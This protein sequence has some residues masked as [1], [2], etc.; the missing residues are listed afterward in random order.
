M[1]F[2]TEVSRI[3]SGLKSGKYR[4]KPNLAKAFM[5]PF[6]KGIERQELERI[7]K[8]KEDRARAAAAAKAA[9]AEQRAKEKA[10]A[11]AQDMVNFIIMTNP[12]IEAT[13]AINKQL[14]T[15]AKTGDFKDAGAFQTFIDDNV[16]Y[17]AGRTEFEPLNKVVGSLPPEMQLR[18]DQVA[19]ENAALNTGALKVGYDAREALEIADFGSTKIPQPDP[20]AV[21]TNA[22]LGMDPV[23]EKTVEPTLTFGKK[24]EDISEFFSGI[25]DIDDWNSKGSEI[26][27]MP[28]GP[29][30][31]RYITAWKTIGEEKRFEAKDDV[32]SMPLDQ[33]R[34][35]LSDTSISTERRELLE[36]RLKSL[37]DPATYEPT[38]LYHSNGS[39]VTARTADEEAAYLSQGFSLVEGPE[40]TDYEA[41]VL[42]KDGGEVKVFS[43][44]QQSEY[45]A[46]GYSVE[47]PAAATP[48]QKRT[49]Y[50]DG[51][52]R[53]VNTQDEMDVAVSEGFIA[54]KAAPEAEYETKTFY[55]DGDEIKVNSLEEQQ[56]A[57]ENGFGPIKFGDVS[58][59]MKD[60]GVDRK[61]AAQIDNGTLKL[62]ANTRG[63]LTIVNN[64][65]ATSTTVQQQPVDDLDK[66][67]PTM[68]EAIAQAIGIDPDANPNWE[69]QETVFNIP[70]HKN[71]DGE[72]IE[73]QTVTVSPAMIQEYKKSKGASEDIG[74]IRSAFGLKGRLSQLAGQAGGLIGK[75]WQPETN[76]A[77]S[78][79]ENL[80]LNTLITLAGTAANGLRDSVWNKQQI[81]TTLAEPAQ[82]WKGAASQQRKLK[83]TAAEIA[84]GIKVAETTINSQYSSP[85]T[86]SKAKVTLS[87]LRS[88]ENKYK[89]VLSL[90]D[91]SVAADKP[92][93]DTVLKN[94]AQEKSTPEADP[95]N[96]TWQEFWQGI[97]N[98]PKNAKKIKAGELTEEQMKKYWEKQYGG[99]Q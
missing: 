18:Q 47:K 69:K 12:E 57:V 23:N 81:L 83:L 80:R 28:E 51:A 77:I 68:E 42:Y 92:I 70:A 2:N 16:K 44:A 43:K 85:S 67:P 93:T 95:N 30:K 14:F 9:A 71:E 60:L 6:I 91:Q 75:D 56:S 97:Q 5:D 29:S 33:V 8:D 48:F 35:E 90:F 82:V 99:K 15:L 94:P 25:K 11:K 73:A 88:L 50:K 37:I 3:R 65:E 32:I 26:S 78:Y 21:Q 54:T 34:F 49:L 98:V 39:K 36:R 89:N 38:E 62:T 76:A 41:R 63:E 86:I 66:V 45:E 55:R 27:A 31:E 17:E 79:L 4:K 13:E 46:L 96:P 40:A 59:I 72:L 64:Y 74:D 52:E 84:S 20:A 1:G 22:M 53:V 58:Q 61:T 24:P 10:D 7:Q 87:G 19:A